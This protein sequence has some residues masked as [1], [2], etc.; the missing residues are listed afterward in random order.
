MITDIIDWY[1][2]LR[3]ID[4]SSFYHYWHY[5]LIHVSYEYR[6]VLFLPLLTLLTDTCVLGVSIIVITDII[7]W[8]MCLKSIDYSD[9]WHYWLIHVYYEYRFVLFLPLLTLLT[10]TCVL[11]V[12]IIVI[13]DIIDWYMCLRSID[14]SDYWH[15]WLIHV[16]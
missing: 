15:Y 10:D 2:C 14:Y 11:G 5:W 6:L 13:T 1:M 7:D 4:L 9:Y 8:Y 16:S 12:S 3:S